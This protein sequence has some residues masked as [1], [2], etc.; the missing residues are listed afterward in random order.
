MIAV[1][2]KLQTEEVDRPIGWRRKKETGIWDGEEN[3]QGS[4]VQRCVAAISAKM[5]RVGVA[6]GRRCYENVAGHRRRVWTWVPRWQSGRSRL[7]RV[8]PSPSVAADRG[9]PFIH[10]RLGPT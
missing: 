5:D 9:A 10:S 7:P 2:H 4:R 1:L 6:H 8:M 3:E